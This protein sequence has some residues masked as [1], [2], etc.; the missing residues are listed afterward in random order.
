MPDIGHCVRQD[1][2]P[3]HHFCD[4]FFD[5]QRFSFHVLLHCCEE[6]TA[7]GMLLVL[8]F[9]LQS[10]E[11]VGNR[12]CGAWTAGLGCLKAVSC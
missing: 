6:V 1:I 11:A 7:P 12:I 8:Q 9:L 2:R 10:L 5:E 4:R 3:Y